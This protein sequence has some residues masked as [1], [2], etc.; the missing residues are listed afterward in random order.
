MVVLADHGV[1]GLEVPLA[2]DLEGTGR[3]PGEIRGQGEGTIPV[4]GRHEGH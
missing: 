1:E 2:S 4:V 3:D